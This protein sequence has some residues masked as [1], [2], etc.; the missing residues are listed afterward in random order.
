MSRRR[1]AAAGPG[2][3]HTR[4]YFAAARILAAG[5]VAV[6]SC[7]GL[8]SASADP[9]A[10][11]GFQS[12]ASAF[13]VVVSADLPGAPLT[14]TPL[15]SGGPSGEASLNS[16]GEGVGYAAF[17]D[18]GQFVISLPGLVAGLLGTGAAGLPPIHLPQ[19]PA[20]PF[21]VTANS[22]TPTA[23]IGAG[24]YNI[25]A[26][27]GQTYSTGKATAGLQIDA[28][29]NAALLTGSS[30][31][32]VNDDGSVVAT[33]TSDL[34]GLTIGPVTLGEI[35]STATETLS[36]DGTV[37]P[38]SSLSITGVRVG[39][40]PVTVSTKGLNVAGTSVP[41]PVSSVLNTVLAADHIKLSF[42]TAQ[43]FKDRVVAPALDITGPLPTKEIGTKNG[44]FDLTVGSATAS[45]EATAPAPPSSVGTPGVGS[46]GSGGDLGTSPVGSGDSGVLPPLPGSDTTSGDV[47]PPVVAPATGTENPQASLSAASA[48]LFDIRSSYLVLCIVGAVAVLLGQLVRLMGVRGPWTSTDG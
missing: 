31:I 28:A 36:N 1:L 8:V 29:G 43:S 22:T 16:L 45:I 39:T 30:S 13:G 7:I 17:P 9:V 34:Q 23:S 12:S 24:A 20:Y 18:P 33:A 46:V 47:I 26:T 35:T 48:N 6:F 14:D 38:S 15:D 40:L 44:T 5:I 2:Q 37:T 3:R 27:T 11:P 32:D 19:L 41:L 4:P 42:V 21:E 10:P 25:S